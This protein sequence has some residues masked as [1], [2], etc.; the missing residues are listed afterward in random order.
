METKEKQAPPVHLLVR[1]E[2]PDRP[3]K[4]FEYDFKQNVIAMGRDPSNDIQVP[5]TTVSRRHARIFYE[6][7]DYFLED[8]GSTHGTEHNNKKLAQGEK[9]L[10]RDGDNITIMS[11]SI[12]FKTTAGSLLDRKPGE[13]TEQ[14][15]RRMVQEVLST[16]GGSKMDPPAL[17]VMNGPDEGTR[18]EIREEQAEVTL[19]RSPECDLPLNDQNI[20][21][22]HCLIKR[23]WNGFTAQDLGSKNGVIVNGNKIEGAQPIKDG[24]EIQVGGLKL[25]FID[26]PSRLL[27]QFGGIAGET[28]NPQSDQANG[29]ASEGDGEPPEANARSSPPDPMPQA[30]V[31]PPSHPPPP[32]RMAPSEPEPMSLP[33]DPELL[34]QVNA[35]IEKVAKKGRLELLILLAGV[36]MFLVAAVLVVFFLL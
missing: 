7:G 24:D 35:E 15:A 6:H 23:T 10:L 11:F 20:S 9:R 22:R 12:V 8:L 31:E 26:P 36:L 28:L 21:R 30:D 4:E 18:Y 2:L 17:R 29:E 25:I 13:K 14:L 1:L 34:K 32:S 16:L 19:G 33:Q 27:D 5:L 3:A